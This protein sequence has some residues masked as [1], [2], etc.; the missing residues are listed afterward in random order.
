[1][2][3]DAMVPNSFQVNFILILTIG[4]K[5]ALNFSGAIYFWSYL[6]GGLEKSG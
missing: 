6:R 2:F 4:I 5:K 3:T 1:M